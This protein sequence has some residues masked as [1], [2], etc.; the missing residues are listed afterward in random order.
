MKLTVSEVTAGP[1]QFDGST[2]MKVACTGSAAVSLSFHSKSPLKLAVGDTLEVDIKSAAGDVIWGVDEPNPTPTAAEIEAERIREEA[3]YKAGTV[4][5][6]PGRPST[7]AELE[8]ERLRRIANDAENARIAQLRR[9][10]DA[11]P[12]SELEKRNVAERRLIEDT[13]RNAREA[14]R[15]R[16]A[17]AEKAAGRA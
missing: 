6:W 15:V 12:H 16:F 2:D 5:T 7:A 8:A 10:E 9:E 4:E 1:T 14:E 3:A 17:A 13:Q 11:R